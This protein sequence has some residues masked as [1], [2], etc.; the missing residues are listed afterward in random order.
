MT[1]F[2]IMHNIINRTDFALY[3]QC[4][5]YLIT[6]HRHSEQNNRMLSISIF[7]KPHT[8]LDITE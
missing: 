8:C 4:Y 7:Q 5:R 2:K 6:D 3:K 1:L